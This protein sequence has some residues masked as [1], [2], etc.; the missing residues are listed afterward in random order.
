V[1][2]ALEI[3][4]EALRPIYLKSSLAQIIDEWE[5]C[6]REFENQLKEKP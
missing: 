2:L 4:P 3:V 1:I 5:D 6:N